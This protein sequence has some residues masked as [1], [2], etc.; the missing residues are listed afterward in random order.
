MMP[1]FE[2]NSK[3]LLKVCSRDME[4]IIQKPK[5]FQ[6]LKRFQFSLVTILHFPSIECW[7]WQIY[8]PKNQRTFS[9]TMYSSDLFSLDDIIL[10]DPFIVESP[11]PTH[12]LW[13][14]LIN[15]AKLIRNPVQDII[16]QIQNY[17]EPLKEI[18]FQDIVYN[19]SAKDMMF[20][21]V[22]LKEA[23][24]YVTSVEDLIPAIKLDNDTMSKWT[25]AVRAYSLTR[26]IWIKDYQP[27]N[28]VIEMLK[29]E[30]YYVQGLNLFYYSML[31]DTADLLSH[32][33]IFSKHA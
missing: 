28:E 20:M 27:F 15:I 22:V 12:A 9:I 17:K 26:N 24:N 2:N 18:L 11:D 5:V 30:N 23:N 31:K 4:V 16:L 7:M 21:E 33:I 13:V 1:I 14:H 25:F 32:K 29:R 8:F 3:H 6:G 10:N 19:Q